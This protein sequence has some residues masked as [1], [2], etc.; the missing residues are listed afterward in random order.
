[1]PVKSPENA[2]NTRD[3]NSELLIDDIEQGVYSTAQLGR[4]ALADSQY[5]RYEVASRARSEGSDELLALLEHDTVSEIRSLAKRGNAELQLKELQGLSDVAGLNVYLSD[6]TADVV[7]GTGT[8]IIFVQRANRDELRQKFGLS[9]EDEEHVQK[10]YHFRSGESID[11]LYW[12]SIDVQHIDG[13]KVWII[14]EYQSDVLH[15]S[16]NKELHDEYFD[17]CDDCDAKGSI[18]ISKKLSEKCH[19]C[20]GT[21]SIPNYPLRLFG[22]IQ[23]LASRVGVETVLLP[24]SSTVLA[25]YDGMI[26]PSKANLLYD[27]VP[28]R[29]G[30]ELHEF[31]SP[32]EI[33]YEDKAPVSS[34]VYYQM[35]TK[36]TP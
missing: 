3:E 32:I 4:L 16:K 5:V 19:T 31:A 6:I 15:R 34:N 29:S 24:T 27:T 26:K 21:G 20:Q 8:E 18:R 10:S 36:K 11:P 23:E 2:I 28:R 30:F 17:P 1:M 25:K 35:T 22:D 12:A 13:T 9:S 7:P 33:G 14:E